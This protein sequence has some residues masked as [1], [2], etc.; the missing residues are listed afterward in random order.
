MNEFQSV[1]LRLTRNQTLRREV[2]KAYG[3]KCMFPGCR[4]QPS[5]EGTLIA[6][7][8]FICSPIP[9]DSRYDQKLNGMVTIDN[10]IVLCPNHHRLVDAYP[11]QFPAD[12]L[13]NFKSSGRDIAEC[14]EGDALPVKKLSLDKALEYWEGH[15]RE[16]RE[17]FWQS[18]FDVNPH[19]LS[20]AFPS[21]VFHMGSKFY[22]GGK[23]TE[24]AGG[25]L[26]DF[27]F[28]EG[29][30]KNILL[31]EIKTP[32]TKLLG[33]QYREGVYAPS[34]DLSGSIAQVLSQAD[35]LQKDF[36]SV[37]RDKVGTIAYNTR[38]LILIG[39]VENELKDRAQIRSFELYRGSL[40]RITVL[41]YDELYLKLFSV[42]SD[43][44][45]V[46]GTGS[47]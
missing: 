13:R 29:S 35:N 5:V 44:K 47:S 43:L 14:T 1:P 3:P 32:A 9:G 11:E 4:E 7:I 12:G 25:N 16:S 45:Q 36:F 20:L 30:T 22:V 42:V 18:F 39:D 31:V 41:T 6:E 2:L 15:R 24:N 28:G 19:V 40:S 27:A 38:S 34:T 23:T 26:A 46:G 8:A 33:R 17:D 37:C 10:V 21:A